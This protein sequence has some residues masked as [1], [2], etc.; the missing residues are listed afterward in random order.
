LRTRINSARPQKAPPQFT[1]VPEL[2][3]ESLVA[4]AGAI[5]AGDAVGD[6][7]FDASFLETTR[8]VAVVS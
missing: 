6:C 5:L 1:A 2:L 8:N 7:R 3:G 4:A